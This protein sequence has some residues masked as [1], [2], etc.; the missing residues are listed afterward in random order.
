MYTTYKE[1]FFVIFP[2]FICRNGNS[3]TELSEGTIGMTKSGVSSDW[4]SEHTEINRYPY[5]CREVMDSSSVELFLAYKKY[6]NDPVWKGQNIRLQIFIM[7]LIRKTELQRTSWI[8]LSVSFLIST[9]CIVTTFMNLLNSIF[10]HFRLYVLIFL[11]NKCSKTL[12][13]W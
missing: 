11:L 9:N 1:F 13:L 8:I 10:K 3:K 4:C 6:E 2:Y 12:F 5:Q 7:G